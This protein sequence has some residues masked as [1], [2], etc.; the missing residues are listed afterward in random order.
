MDFNLFLYCTVGRRA[1]LERGMA[2]RRGDLYQ[3]MLDEIAEYASAA[4]EW[5]Y[6]GIG[7]PEHHLQIEGFEASG[8]LGPMAMWLGQHTKRMKVI[9]CGWVSTTH[10]PLRAAEYIAALDNMLRGR[11]SFGLVRGY[12][13]RWVENFKIRPEL[14]AVGPWNKDTPEDDLNRE[15]FTEYV[16]VVLKALRSETFSHRGRFWQFPPEGF[17]N[18]HRHDVYTRFGAGVRE[19]MAID[20]VGIAPRPYQKP[21]P[22]LYGGFT[23]SLRTSLFWARHLGR[24]IVLADNLPFC[25]M[26]WA[27][28]TEEAA[29]HGHDVVDGDQAAWGGILLCAP[30]DA[31]AEEWARDML[32]LWDNWSVP[33]GQSRP[34][35]LIGS[36]DTITRQIEAAT[37]QFTVNDLFGIIPQGILD[38]GRN[39]ASLELIA[40]K[41]MPRFA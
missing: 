6:A 22:Q 37:E 9:S 5:G 18:P 32:W 15:Y 2:G 8:E 26:L 29:R 28:Y 4:D 40:T 30:T 10:N 13:A 24:P 23:G 21:M 7:H 36:P 1:E 16:D 11:F 19:D 31:E 3:R 34:M 39:L 14:A 35:L 33:F 27:K 17:R 12:Q 20:E 41:V 25:K 38:P